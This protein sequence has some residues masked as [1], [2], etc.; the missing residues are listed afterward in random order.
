MPCWGLYFGCPS[1]V[2]AH[3]GATQGSLLIWVP[4]HG[5]FLLGCPTSIFA[6]PGREQHRK[7][8][9]A[10]DTKKD[11]KE[12]TST[13]ALV[14]N[15]PRASRAL[16]RMPAKSIPRP[17]A[18]WGASGFAP[19]NPARSMRC[20]SLQGSPGSSRDASLA[21]EH[22]QIPSASPRAALTARILLIV[23]T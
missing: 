19:Q 5:L 23:R 14:L 7:P 16:L 10:G 12:V 13:P 1:S 22:P 4:S 11:A 3:L 8:P 6:N 20:T 21:S 15:P 18:F 9:A 17:Q 2:F